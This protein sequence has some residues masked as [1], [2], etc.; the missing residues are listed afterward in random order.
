MSHSENP[1]IEA[2]QVNRIALKLPPFWRHNIQLWFIQVEA[3]FM[4]SGITADMTKYA[5]L[6]ASIDSETL[7][8]VSDVLNQPPDTNKYDTLKTRL[9]AEFADSENRRVKQLLGDLQLGDKKPSSLLRQ[10]RDLAQGKVNEDFLQSLWLQRLPTNIQ[11]V[12]SASNE[13]LPQLAIL[14]DKIQEIARDSTAVYAIRTTDADSLEAAIGG[15]KE[16]TTGHA[17]VINGEPAYVV[18]LRKQMEM[19]TLKVDKLAREVTRTGRSR[20][21]SGSQQRGKDQSRHSQDRNQELCYYHSTF[22]AQARKCRF[23]CSFTDQGN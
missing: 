3:A 21:R 22:G 11:T 7:A 14:A 20:H 17:A 8:H 6:V 16:D 10:M 5:S 1:T 18:E 2:A 9:I 12:L 4:L 23:P 15:K 13:E 19:L